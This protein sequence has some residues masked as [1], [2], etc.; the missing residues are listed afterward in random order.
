MKVEIF[1]HFFTFETCSITCRFLEILYVRAMR[2][3]NKNFILRRFEESSIIFIIIIII[4]IIT[5]I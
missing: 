4:I 2:Y 5:S 3:I 1:S